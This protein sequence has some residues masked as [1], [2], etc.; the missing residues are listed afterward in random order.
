MGYSRWDSSDWDKYSA[1]TKSKSMDSLFKNN[2]I[3]SKLNP[4]G[5]NIRESRDSDKNPNSTAIIVGLDVTGSMGMIADNLA[6]EGLGILVQEIIDR[7]PV[8][9]PHIMLCAIGDAYYDRS[10]FQTTQF[11]ADIS[12]AKQLEDF[13]LEKGGGGNDFESYNLPWYFAS[14]HTAIDCFEKRNKKGYLFT[15]GDEMA[16]RDLKKS[17]IKQIF[18]DE[19]QTDYSSEQLYDMACKM[20]HVFHVVI[21]QGSFASRNLTRV[22]DSWQN[23]IGQNVLKLSNYKDLAQTIVSCI[24]INEGACYDDVVSSWSDDTSVVVRKAISELSKK[25]KISSDLVRF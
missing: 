19:V 7:K 3:N 4:F 16:P 9:D 15:V 5:V 23:L 21:E 20:Y 13:Y 25:E 18:G 10:P 14:T 11:E 8:S 2:T 17:Q 6:K 1:T 22:Y 24:E 12:I